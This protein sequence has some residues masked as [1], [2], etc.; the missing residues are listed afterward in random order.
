[1]RHL[2]PL[3]CVRKQATNSSRYCIYLFRMSPLPPLSLY[4]IFS[5]HVGAIDKAVFLWEKLK[6]Q[7]DAMGVRKKRAKHREKPWQLELF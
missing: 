3:Y 2:C 4:R 1:M 7:Q 6:C 5:F